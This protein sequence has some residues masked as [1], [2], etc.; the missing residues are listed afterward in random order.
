MPRC[1]GAHGGC[2]AHARRRFTDAIKGRRNASEAN[3]ILKKIA[4]L[5]RR[6]ASVANREGDAKVQAR[7]AKVKPVLED[8]HRTATAMADRY[9]NQGLMGE[10]LRYLLNHW[11]KL[12]RFLDHVDLPIDNNPIEQAIRPFTVGR[13]NWLFSGSP[14]GA[15]ASAFMYSLVQTAKLNG[16]EPKHYLQKPCS[17]VTPTPRTT[18]NA[19]RCCRCF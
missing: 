16:W 19:V 1:I 10:A 7:H 6:E 9:L 5:Y 3:A 17:S 4:K 8:I 2:W 14:R 11:D 15:H 12:T 13:R 18:M